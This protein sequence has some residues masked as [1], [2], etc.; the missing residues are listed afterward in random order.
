MAKQSQKLKVDLD[1]QGE[2]TFEWP[3]KIPTAQG[4]LEIKITYLHRTRE[5]LAALAEARVAKARAKFEQDMAKQQEAAKA[6]A[7]DSD[8][9][10][11]PIERALKSFDDV[12]PVQD[13]IEAMDNEVESLMEIVRGWDVGGH[14]FNEHNLR[15]LC[16]RYHTAAA[17]LTKQYG[18]ALNEGRLGNSG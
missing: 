6:A 16:N 14:E 9:D 8:D 13:L 7:A 1:P 18:I 11:S 2:I 17:T 3:V 4:E 15:R 10:T 12:K 5:E